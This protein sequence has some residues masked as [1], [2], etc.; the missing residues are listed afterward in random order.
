MELI[1]RPP[2]VRPAEGQRHRSVRAIPGQPLEPGI[3]VATRND[4][5]SDAQSRV[6]FGAR[7]VRISVT[8]GARYLRLSARSLRRT[9][10]HRVRRTLI[11]TERPNGDWL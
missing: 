2:H 5:R 4:E 7:S 3:A 11:E 10:D 1:E 9:R 8:I 6:V